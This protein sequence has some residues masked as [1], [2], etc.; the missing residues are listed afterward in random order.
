ME[1]NKGNK[2]KIISFD[3][4][5]EVVIIFGNGESKKNNGRTLGIGE[6]TVSVILNIRGKR[7]DGICFM[8][9]EMT[10]SLMTEID[11]FIKNKV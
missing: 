3:T 4:K 8:Q 2:R 7:I 5:I 6:T 11:D 9:Y 10:C 1:T